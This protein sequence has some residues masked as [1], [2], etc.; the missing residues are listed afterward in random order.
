[1]TSKLEEISFFDIPLIEEQYEIVNPEEI[2]FDDEFIL[3]EKSEPNPYHIELLK[4]QQIHPK[5]KDKFNHKWWG[6]HP[7]RHNTNWEDWTKQ[8]EKLFDYMIHNWSA[9]I[10]S[11]TTY[12]EIE[13]S[14]PLQCSLDDWID[15]YEEKHLQGIKTALSGWIKSE[16]DKK[17]IFQT[18]YWRPTRN[19]EYSS[20]V[21]LQ[22]RKFFIFKNHYFNLFIDHN[23]HFTLEFW[24]WKDENNPHFQPLNEFI[25]PENNC[26]P[27][28]YWLF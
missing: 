19:P 4:P 3:R 17:D 7:D 12:W 14:Y 5:P 13:C 26:I 18:F 25:I 2:P 28:K 6:I 23:N 10:D 11:L 21:V 16:V 24:G 22:Y 8:G 20:F 15:E 1:M 9:M 27:E